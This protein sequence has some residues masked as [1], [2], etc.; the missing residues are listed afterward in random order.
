MTAAIIGVRE[1]QR[2]TSRL[3]REVQRDGRTFHI[4]VHG[5]DTGVTL[6][7]E[8]EGEGKGRAGG[9][10]ARQVAASPL[11]AGKSPELIAAQLAHVEAMREAAGRVGER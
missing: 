1:L 2:D 6:S 9:A 8:G 10:S 3:I 5:R 7:R 11:Y 4:A